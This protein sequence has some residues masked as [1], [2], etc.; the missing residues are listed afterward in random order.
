MMLLQNAM[1]LTFPLKE[2]PGAQKDGDGEGRDFSGSLAYKA[3]G[4]TKS[5]T[6]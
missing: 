5:R 2:L 1:Q 3:R 4:Y 6:T